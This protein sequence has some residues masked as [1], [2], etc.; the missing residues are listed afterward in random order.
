[1]PVSTPFT[2]ISP[3]TAVVVAARRT[4]VASVGR[5]FADASVEDLTAPVLRALLADLG[6]R[7]P[8]VDDV[9]I[10][11]CT[12]PG[13]DIA[14]IAALQAGL[15]VDV[16]GVTVD[17]Q[18]AQRSRGDPARRGPG[19]R[20]WP[21]P[22][23]G[24]RRRERQ[25]LSPPGAG[26][27]RARAL[28]RPRHGPRGRGARRAARDQPRAPG[29]LRRPLAPAGGGGPRP[30]R[31]RQGDRAGRAGRGRRPTADDADREPAGRLPPGVRAGR[32]R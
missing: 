22:G 21:A 15:G 12:G 27:V 7:A 25:H 3:D 16:P 20:G 14:R 29:R 9:L 19:H 30:G 6:P 11:N 8:R 5:A 32:A 24:R 26:P 10:G 2:P 28:R 13:G 18:C 31:L 1:M 4:A 17:R 23:P